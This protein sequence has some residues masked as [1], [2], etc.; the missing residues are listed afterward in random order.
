MSLVLASNHTSEGDVETQVVIPLITRGDYLGIDLMQIKAKEF[1]PA[2][3]IGKGGKVKKGYIPDYCVYALSLP[4]IAIEVKAPGEG[5]S[6]AWEEAGLYG[7][8]V[9]KRFDGQTN[10][11]SF[12][13]ATDGIDFAAGRWD[14]QNPIVK[15]KVAALSHGSKDLLALQALLG[16]KAVMAS[17]AA[18]NATL[19]LSGFKRPFNQGN[20][21]ALIG[22]RL[23]PN[24]FASD[25]SPVLRRYFSSRDQN[26]DPE[27]FQKAYVSSNE[28]TSYDKILESFLVDRL[29]RSR[30]RVEIVTT[31]NKADDVS[32]RL[33]EMA[34]LASQTGDIQLITGGVGTGKSLFARRYK[35][36]LQ[37]DSLRNNTDWA[38]LDFNFAPSNLEAAE[39][40]VCSSFSKSI[41]EEGAPLNLQDD[42]DQ[43]RIFASDL[44]DRAAYYR[45]VEKSAAGRGILEQARDLEAWRQDE[46]KLAMGIARHLQNDLGRVVIAVFD[47]VDRRDVANQLAAFQLAL[48]FMDQVR[49]LVILQMRDTTFEAHKNERPLDTYKTGQIFHISPPRFV[50]VVKRRLELSLEK[51]AALAPENITFTTP[52]GV[53]ITYPRERSSDF[54]RMIYLDLFQRPNNISRILE[55]LAGRNVRKALDMFFAIITSGHMPEDLITTVASGGGI[56]RFPEYLILRILM[57]QDY[58]FYNDNSGFVANLFYCKRDWVRPNNF[59][60]PEILFYLISRRKMSGDNGQMG[61]VSVGRLQEHLET[62]GFVKDDIAQAAVYL[63]AKDLIEADLVGATAISQ[64]MSIKASASG[65]AHMR[66]L[67][68]RAEY[69][70]SLLPT[71]PVDNAKF[72]AQIY[73]QMQSEN[74]TGKQHF[75]QRISL[76]SSFK[77]YLEKQYDG[78]KH[79]IGYANH[80]QNG[81]RYILQKIDEAIA[82]E[83]NTQG[84]PTQSDW[85]D[86]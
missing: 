80:P 74:R 63:L 53:N 33:S 46:T 82:F 32:K 59:I 7:H 1:L 39:H 21:P 41:I 20:G 50:D 16:L 79:H 12:I 58:R 71:T 37:P 11:C 30:S 40:W 26:K 81:A 66:I 73:E 9:N 52:S 60:I 15:C 86:N 22:S 27:I 2:F 4:V 70:S 13:I 29:S 3:D 51:L 10:P 54:L 17:A 23:D 76:L 85:L 64:V 28:V 62:F 68:S 38:F 43:E 19:R 83:R 77:E 69:V 24:T 18:T 42:D 56:R 75:H 45:R 34:V 78:L 49:C 44:A 6:A 55:S 84:R 5:I 36:F 25:L 65:W 31:K 47:N 72:E 35:E 57:R 48:W 61:F 67:A 8:A 14:Q